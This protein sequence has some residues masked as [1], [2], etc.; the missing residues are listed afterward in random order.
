MACAARIRIGLLLAA[1]LALVFVAFLNPHFAVD[2]VN[3]D[4]A[5]F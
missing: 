4:W 3:R 1:V 2:L 5:C